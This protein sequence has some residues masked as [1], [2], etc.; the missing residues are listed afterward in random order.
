M[1]HLLALF[2]L[3]VVFFPGCTVPEP[4]ENG[5]CRELRR[6]RVHFSADPS[7]TPEERAQLQRATDEWFVF[8]DA[9]VDFS[10]SF[11]LDLDDDH[12]HIHRTESW[13][14]I[15]KTQ[16]AKAEQPGYQLAGWEKSNGTVFLVIDRVAPEDLWI[17]AAHELGHVVGL[18][19]P[20]CDGPRITCVHSPDP[21]AL[22]ASV[23]SA[24]P[25]GESDL[26]LCRASC[27][28]P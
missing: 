13:M 26:A 23:F 25:F 1:K 21:S 9:R 5:V 7:F 28:C 17:L 2:V 24:Q 11:D 27:V 19:W 8:S 18:A 10:L 16:E 20:D 15:V 6:V 12:T 3:L 22:M 14:K 4:D